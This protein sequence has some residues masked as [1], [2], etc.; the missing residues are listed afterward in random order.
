M[1]FPFPL[2]PAPLAPK[3]RGLRGWAGLTLGSGSQLLQFG[4]LASVQFSGASGIGVSQGS[5]KPPYSPGNPHTRLS[6]L[7]MT[8]AV[9]RKCCPYGQVPARWARCMEGVGHCSGSLWLASDN[10]GTVLGEG[11]EQPIGHSQL[12]KSFYLAE[13]V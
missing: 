13:S 2:F 11:R 9:K 5:E 10:K 8:S 4:A 3:G 6:A 12:A 1:L 7:Q